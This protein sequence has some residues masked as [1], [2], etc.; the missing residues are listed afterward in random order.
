MRR[1]RFE[2]SLERI[3]SAQWEMFE[4][5]CAD[6]LAGEFAGLRTLAF[7]AGDDGRDGYLYS[8]EEEPGVY[9]QYS[10]REDWDRKIRES[11]LRLH[12]RVKGAREL[13]YLTNQIVGPAEDKLKRELREKYGL[14]L[15][16]RD[17]NW[18]LE[19]RGTTPQREM[20][21]EELAQ[22]IVDPLL[23][24]KE[25]YHDKA[26]AL[27][28][29]EARTACVHLA[30][31]WADEDQSKNLT[32]T[33][34]EALI[35]AVLSQSPEEWRSL[36]EIV[37][38]V[39]DM[40][41]SGDSAQAANFADAAVRRLKNKRAVEVEGVDRYRLTRDER[42]RL[43][44]RLARL[45][46]DDEALGQ[47]LKSS[48]AQV[49][50]DSGYRGRVDHRRLAL[51]VRQ[52]VEGHLLA[53]GESFVSALARG[54]LADTEADDLKE[55]SARVIRQDY[56]RPDPRLATIVSMTAE[57]VLTSP[58]PEVDRHLR[59][60][61][62][63]YTLMAFLQETPDVQGVVTKMF[64]TGEIWIDTTVALPLF[65]ETLIDEPSGRRFTNMMNVAAECGLKFFATEGVIEE[66]D[67]HFGRC[68]AYSRR[69]PGDEW[70]GKPP[71]L[72]SAY[73]LAGRAPDAF[74]TWVDEFRGGLRPFDDVADYLARF[75]GIEVANLQDEADKADSNVHRITEEIWRE[76]HERRR[77]IAS[78]AV[79]KA[80][81]VRH[82]LENYLGV[83]GRRGAERA[84]A[85]GYSTWW[86]TTD[87][88]A[89]KTLDA[90]RTELGSQA[91]SSP[92]MSPD[93]LTVYLSVGPIRRRVRKGLSTR[94]S[95][96]PLMANYL[97]SAP[98]VP[99]DVLNAARDIR[100]KF[101]GAPPHLL[102]RY[103]RD[104]LDRRRRRQGLV[105]QLGMR[106]TLDDVHAAA[107]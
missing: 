31:Q 65:A 93:F 29:D 81:L 41:P 90:L 6:F 17:R 69:A 19:R 52:V 5:L 26:Q 76:A 105:S 75:F 2:L 24:S 13:I 84:N 74:M 79:T 57:Q 101:D 15:D 18:F 47:Q 58:A 32:K 88:V 48:V 73:T 97:T 40:V 51:A 53:Q 106:A 34:F 25:L 83:L 62:D 8:S 54:H 12:D 7:A 96:L 80:R 49:I 95:V 98:E 42:K 67:S 100:S 68:I 45:Q 1:E 99:H 82:D 94:E 9:F 89:Y 43:I 85:F 46:H 37:R 104:D 64:S 72:Y 103:V 30:M 61:A 87:R 92:V 3:R 55:L 39:L 23:R 4:H 33:A 70:T 27:S 107:T 60:F 11:G 66:V 14:R 21:A 38:G 71:F 56:Q 44:D 63:S 86:L 59:A 78:D 77:A 36:S 91:P 50:R 102:D 16:V 28:S 20:A 22:A 35:R 10:V